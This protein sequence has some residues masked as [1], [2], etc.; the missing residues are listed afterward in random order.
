MSTSCSNFKPD[1]QS[2]TMI[3]VGY[4]KNSVRTIRFK[5]D[6]NK[7]NYCFNGDIERTT[8]VKINPYTGLRQKLY[9][10][11]RLSKGHS[12][13]TSNQKPLTPE[14]SD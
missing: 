6:L 5:P 10:L 4:H 1:Y 7:R 14:K 12:I 3:N 13:L 2:A 9:Q 8:G 11:V